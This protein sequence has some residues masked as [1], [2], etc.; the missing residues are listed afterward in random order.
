MGRVTFEQIA[1]AKVSKSTV[2][3]A[4]RDSPRISKDTRARIR[5]LAEKLGYRPDPMLA[6]Y[7][8]H[9]R[10]YKKPRYQ[11]T[12]AWIN[13]RGPRGLWRSEPF[14][15]RFLN[16]ARARA[17]EL[18]FKLEEIEVPDFL[19][20]GANEFRALQRALVARGVHGVVLPYPVMLKMLSVEW[21]DF[22]VVVLGDLSEAFQR[23]LS[24]AAVTIP[25]HQVCAD[26]Y[27]N[28]RLALKAVVAAGYT[29]IGFV[30]KDWHNTLNDFRHVAGYVVTREAGPKVR[31]FP[32]LTEPSREEFRAWFA[33]HRPD[34][35]LTTTNEVSP[36]LAEMKVSV[37][38]QVGVAH[39]F[40]GPEEV[41]WSGVEEHPDR[42]GVAAVEL[43]ADALARNERGAPPFCKKLCVQGTWRW[44]ATT[45]CPAE[46]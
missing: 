27:E 14:S 19:G 26:A 18:G 21:T 15:M 7:Q 5:G 17:E 43:L 44:G 4:L 10:A 45:V 24:D 34:A 16:A 11:A 40:I 23:G 36:W 32:V 33:R 30:T 37:P 35:V 39:V 25:F 38:G 31:T 13:D 1:K 41:G 29:R 28:M 20:V 3:L 42:I 9:V 12:I 8:A 46:G 6:A 22:A 2:C